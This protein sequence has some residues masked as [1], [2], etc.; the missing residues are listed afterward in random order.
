MSYRSLL[1]VVMLALCAATQAATIS[2]TD[3]AKDFN[4]EAAKLSPDGSKLGV[5]IN[6]DGKRRLAVFD[7]SSFEAIGGADLGKGREV[8]NFYWAN[9]ERLVMEIWETVGWKDQSEY[10]GEL[11][12]VDYDGSNQEVIFGYRVASDTSGTRVKTKE[13]SFA[14]ARVI[15]TLP[16]DD[17]N[18]LI[19]SQPMSSDGARLPSAVKLNVYDGR[20]SFDKVMS[21]VTYSRFIANRE[22]D[23]KFASGIDETNKTRTYRLNDDEWVEIKNDAG[24]SFRP[25]ALSQDGNSLFYLDKVNGDKEGLFTLDL[26]SGD[27]KLIYVDVNVDISDVNFNADRSAVYAVRV[28]DGYSTYV[29]FNDVG[30]ESELFRS[31]L[32]TFQ[33]Y[34]INITSRSRDRSLWVLY[35]SNDIDAGSYYLYDKNQNRLMQLFANLDHIDINLMAESTPVTFPSFDKKPIPAYVTYPVNMAEGTQV[36]LVTLVHGGPHGPRDYWSFDRDVQ[37]LA[38]QGYA[39]LR[40]NY[41]GSGGY[42]D[43]FMSEGYTQWGDAIQNDII[44]GTRWLIEQGRIDPNKVCIMGASFGGYSAAMAPM[45]APDLFQCAV[46]HVGVFD[47]EMMYNEGDIPTL[48]FGE[49]YLKQAIGDDV[50][51]LRKFSPVNNVQ[52]LKAEIFIAHGKEDRRVPFEHALALKK[53][54]DEHDKPYEWFVKS[55]E[56]H[57]FFDEANRAEYYQRVSQFLAKHLQ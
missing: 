57:G 43:V 10:R 46:A 53:A 4:Y 30:D 12:A 51:Q 19:S 42:G 52:T 28:D 24:E 37:M 13:A 17:R 15:S 8:G 40:V 33:G 14:V 5:A 7:I 41:R 44:A 56:A 31:L 38:A 54:L 16:N 34:N 11:F 49:E 48:L 2:P 9:D 47:L 35:V 36:P 29:V 22:G 18:I 21:P 27:T 45:L 39:V 1:A 6:V 25:L 55:S 26:A 20:L 32:S 3:L 23:V 50:T